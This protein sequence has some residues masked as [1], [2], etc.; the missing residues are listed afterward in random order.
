[1]KLGALI[2]S[3]KDSVY[4]MYTMMQQN[5]E[6]GCMITMRSKNPDSFM[7]Q[8]QGVDMAKFPAMPLWT[9][10]Y[11][12]DCGHLDDAEAGRYLMMLIHLW[13]APRQRFPND[14]V[15]LA[16]KF[17]RSIDDVQ[18]QIRPLI[19]EFCT[20]DGNWISQTRLKREFS[21]VLA[22]SEAQSVRAKARWVKEKEVPHSLL[23]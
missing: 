9:D 23:D 21:F 11:L 2:S 8:S 14:D 3:G 10:A 15:W 18:S 20:T 6:I 1:M 5:Y 7:F 4:A 22:Q 16:R 12:A 19:S 13:R 17:R